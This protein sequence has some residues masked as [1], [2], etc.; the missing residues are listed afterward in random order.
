MGL[1][2]NNCG[3]PA[4]CRTFAARSKTQVTQMT[5]RFLAHLC[6]DRKIIEPLAGRLRGFLNPEAYFGTN[7][8]FS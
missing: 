4:G 5:P 3:R 7:P 1:L 2:Q 8:V 6:S